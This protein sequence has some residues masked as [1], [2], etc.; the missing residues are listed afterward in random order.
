MRIEIHNGLN[1]DQICNVY[2]MASLFV[3]D[4]YLTVST[5]YYRMTDPFR[6]L[7]VEDNAQFA[8][9][10][11]SLLR[12]ALPETE[13]LQ[14]ADGQQAW[15]LIWKE[16]F[17]L[18]ISAWNLP[19]LSGG[20]LLL[21]LRG[22][23]KTRNLPFVMLTARAD[24]VSIMYAM[25][26]G[27]TAYITK[28][29]D[30]GYFIERISELLVMR[31]DELRKMSA[32]SRPNSGLSQVDQRK[33]AVNEVLKRIRGGD[34]NLPVLP[35]MALRLNEFAQ[36]PDV[37]I[38]D[39]TELIGR[40]GSVSSKLIAIANS[41]Y[42][43]GMRRFNTLEE[44]VLRLGFRQ[45]QNYVMTIMTRGLFEVEDPFFGS[46]LK[47]LWVH[48]LA[49]GAAARGVAQHIRTLNQDVLYGKGLL[50]DIGKLLLLHTIA[51]MPQ[52]NLDTEGIYNV[53]DTMH[54][55]YGA[56]LLKHWKFSQ[57]F[58]E[59]C[60]YHHDLGDTTLW[61]T[62]LLAVSFANVLV[63]ETGWSLHADENEHPAKQG[64]A[65]RLGL[66]PSDVAAILEE[67]REYVNETKVM[68]WGSLDESE[69]Q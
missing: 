2:T 69:L 56:A 14:A 19:L 30:R 55:E 63:R 4:V 36:R 26:S 67:T 37:R 43:R 42:Y 60:L 40:D 57:D 44:A 45:T 16:R 25:R 3:I 5:F 52:R 17:D 24:R 64:M 23:Y 46:L 7:I 49:T 31:R 13:I 51:G 39:V 27:V 33:R 48:S 6:L 61:P 38:Q 18:I 47:Q 28:P 15:A 10:L 35:E 41:S 68:I 22:H 50:H 34:I 54:T 66:K 32:H 29:F 62:E 59:V 20:D 11:L 21:K 9:E 53:L 65:Q 58:S 12:R 1:A 8:H